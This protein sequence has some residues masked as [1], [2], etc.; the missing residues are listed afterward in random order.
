VTGYALYLVAPSSCITIDKKSKTIILKQSALCRCT[1]LD[2]K[3]FEYQCHQ[4]IVAIIAHNVSPS[5]YLHLLHGAELNGE[6]YAVASASNEERQ[7]LAAP[8][9]RMQDPPDRDR[10]QAPRIAWS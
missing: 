9:R 6:I 3:A 7:F 2:A 5:G 8:R 1:L 4:A 10:E